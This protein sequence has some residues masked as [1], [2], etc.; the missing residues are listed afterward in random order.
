MSAPAMT[1]EQAAERLNVSRTALYNA[2]KRGELTCIRLGRA[3]RIPARVIE[4]ME[5]GTWPGSSSTEANGAPS[6]RSTAKPSAR[7]F[8]PVIV[9]RR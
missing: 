4:E 8:E 9:P 2:C 3:I 1:I 5:N 6:I 7:R